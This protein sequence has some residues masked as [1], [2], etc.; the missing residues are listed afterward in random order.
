[1]KQIQIGEF[2]EFLVRKGFV[3]EAKARFYVH[4]VEMYLRETVP[5]GETR[6]EGDGV[7]G[8]PPSKGKG[9]SVGTHSTS[10]GQAPRPTWKW[11]G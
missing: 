8:A 3:V 10:S 6:E 2:A 4:W 7:A 11:N 1:M 5:A 9:G